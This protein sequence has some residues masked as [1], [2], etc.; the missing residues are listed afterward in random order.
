MLCIE[1]H[2]LLM[3][4][5]ILLRTPFVVPRCVD[6]NGS[7]LHR[8]AVRVFRCIRWRLPFRNCE[9]RRLSQVHLVKIK[10]RLHAF[11]SLWG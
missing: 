1:A 3:P 4:P 6:K 9:E 2:E 11:S 7:W 10:Q 5:P 8:S